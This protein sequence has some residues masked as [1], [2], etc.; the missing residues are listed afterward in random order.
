ML[1]SETDGDNLH[2]VGVE[3]RRHFRNNEKECL[4]GKIDGL[5]RNSKKKNIR[6]MYKGINEFQD[7]YKS[8]ITF[9]KN[10]ILDFLHI[11]V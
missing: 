10:E 1:P 9:V 7:C 3:V 4:K 11:T 8:R 2:N 5:A 6:E